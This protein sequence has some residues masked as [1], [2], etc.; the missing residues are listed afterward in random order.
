MRVPKQNPVRQAIPPIEG[1]SSN[2]FL[3]L[4]AISGPRWLL[5]V[6]V[7]LS[8]VCPSLSEQSQ[9]R[10]SGSSCAQS[11]LAS[12]F[13]AASKALQ[14]GKLDPAERGFQ[15]VLR[16]GPNAGA[17][18]NLGVV[19]MRNQDWAAAT[20]ALKQAA[21]LAPSMSGVRLNLALVAFRQAKYEDAVPYLKTVVR[22]QPTAVQPTYLL[23]LSYF[24]TQEYA[25]A[26]TTLHA[27]WPSLDNDIAYLYVLGLA[28]DKA[29]QN[30]V[31]EK[32]WGRLTEIGADTAQF[33]MLMGKA[34][35]N[36][37]DPDKAIPEFEAAEKLDPNLPFLHYNW[38]RAYVFINQYEEAKAQFLK[39]VALEPEIPYSYDELA[40]VYDKLG[41]DTQ[42]EANYQKAL[43]LNS[44][45]PDSYFGLAKIYERRGQLD[46]ALKA[47]D[48]ALALDAESNNLHYL[49]ARVLQKMGKQTEAKAEF[50]EAKRLLDKHRGEDT[51][52]RQRENPELNFLSK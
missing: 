38:G 51:L 7:A 16:C 20:H 44:Q 13:Q 5:P 9:K 8:M 48:T 29:G 24:F 43:K 30:A 50:A 6:L 28:A 10:G 39:D 34:Y 12:R 17:Y 23:G 37:G 42:A 46:Q 49:R 45:V 52:E 31:S 26:A 40:R 14:A 22:E 18:A 3:Q 11:D 2:I 1:Q 27:I 21:R 32:A 33:H 41:D 19:Y 25:Q 4:R 36:R 35:Y 15:S 47:V